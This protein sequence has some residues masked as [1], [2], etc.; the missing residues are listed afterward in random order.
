MGD[1]RI[2]KMKSLRKWEEIFLMRSCL[3]E[4]M[5]Q[6]QAKAYIDAMKEEVKYNHEEHN[7]KVRKERNKKKKS[8]QEEFRKLTNSKKSKKTKK[9]KKNRK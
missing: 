7:K 2:V 8:F 9:S 5:T 1:E 3:K 6:P 4:G